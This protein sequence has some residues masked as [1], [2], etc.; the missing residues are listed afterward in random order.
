MAYA[1]FDLTGKVALV[2]G[3]NGGIGLG[4]A[5]GLAA[6]GANV[7]VWGQ[8]PEK[9]AKAE[10]T[11]KAYGG[12]VLVQQV[13]V[14]DEAAVVA[15]VAEVLK[16]FGR[17][18]FAAANAGVGG[19]APFEEMT[20]EKW[21]RVTTV[22]L[23]AVFWTFREAAKHMIER[24][25]AGDPGGS[26]LVTSSTSAIH[27]A[28]RNQAYA[29][30]KAAVQAMIRGLAV[31]YAR[32][33]IRA[34]AVLPGWI[35]SDMTAGLQAWDKFNEKAI[36]RVPMRRWGEPEDFSGL[37]VYLASDASKFH[38]GDSMVIDGGYTI[39]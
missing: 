17:L 23:D 28:P 39:F 22:N 25:N 37:A 26:L 32:Y 33:G 18:D 3:G 29:S 38:T 35:R 5:G 6:A 13:D 36:G 34:N 7:A 21:R 19:G 1:P 30:T 15:G 31:E 2:T 11:L 12:D 14:A 16:T 8:N 10:A 4:M 9:N 24:A 27:G 20:T